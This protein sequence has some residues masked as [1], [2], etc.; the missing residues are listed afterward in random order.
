MRVDRWIVHELVQAGYICLLLSICQALVI[1]IFA[2]CLF[3]VVVHGT[4]SWLLPGGFTRWLCVN[5]ID[6]W[7]GDAAIAAGCGDLWLVYDAQLVRDVHSFP[8]HAGD[9][10]VITR[11][12]YWTCGRVL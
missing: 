7:S 9:D 6:R 5:K 2:F 1:C 3:V 8:F 10:V 4:G 12:C 11:R